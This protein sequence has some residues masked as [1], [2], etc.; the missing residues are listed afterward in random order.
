ME[1]SIKLVNSNQSGWSLAKG[2]RLNSVDEYSKTSS[3]TLASGIPAKHLQ[4]LQRRKRCFRLQGNSISCTSH[5]F[6]AAVPCPDRSRERLC[7]SWPSNIS[8]VYFP[9]SLS[10]GPNISIQ[11][12]CMLLPGLVR[13]SK[14]ILLSLS[15][16]ENEM[17]KG[18]KDWM[19]L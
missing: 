4:K 17:I 7:V 14:S 18:K 10:V 6:C 1:C 16:G 13:S 19:W 3:L 11:T 5:M 2:Q 15:Q 9:L 8:R 12:F